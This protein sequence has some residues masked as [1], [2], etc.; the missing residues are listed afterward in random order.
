MIAETRLLLDLWQPG[1]DTAALRQA[2]LDSGRF[3][4]LT[5]RRLRNIVAE[6]FAPRY[7]VN[8]AAP[9]RLLKTARDALSRQEMEQLLFLFTCRANTILADFVRDVYWPAYSAGRETISVDDARVFVSRANQEGKTTS[10]WSSG[11][12]RNVASYVA[13][14]CADFGLLERGSKSVRRIQPCRIEPRVSILLAHDLRFAGSGDAAVVN[15]PDWSLFG[16]TPPD[17]LD[18]LRRQALSG[19]FMIQSA[20][21]ITRITWRCENW[22]QV[23][24]G[25][26]R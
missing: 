5:A 4:N 13:G 12:I 3:P 20:A 24:D 9:A 14:C 18:E 16:L 15:H 21:A 26:T 8:D 17:V 22:E 1:M 23:I 10:A 19:L 7:L 11:T 6:C 25:F 2:A